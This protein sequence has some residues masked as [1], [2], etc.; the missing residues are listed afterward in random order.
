MFAIHLLH[1]CKSLWPI[2]IEPADSAK[3]SSN[4]AGIRKA[5]YKNV[6]NLLRLA[7]FI[8]CDLH[9]ISAARQAQCRCQN[10]TRKFH[11]TPRA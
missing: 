5:A 4:Y 8:F 11:G 7:G 2:S 9:C 3:I 1:T 10:E 6:L